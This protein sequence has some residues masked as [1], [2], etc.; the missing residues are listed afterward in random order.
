MKHL[1]L[2][3]QPALTFVEVG[4]FLF[5]EIFTFK[6]TSLGPK[7]FCFFML[8]PLYFAPELVAQMADEHGV[9]MI[10]QPEF[11]HWIGTSFR[12]GVT[13][14]LILSGYQ[15]IERL[16]T[17]QPVMR[18]TIS[19]ETV[20]KEVSRPP[21]TENDSQLDDETQKHHQISALE[22]Q[23][24]IFAL[25]AMTDAAYLYNHSTPVWKA[26]QE[27]RDAACQLSEHNITLPHFEAL[28]RYLGGIVDA[29]KWSIDNTGHE[30]RFTHG[31][32]TADSLAEARGQ[33]P[34]MKAD[35]PH[36]ALA[37]ETC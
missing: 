5:V 3:T 4:F 29:A 28:D 24:T 15:V 17:H 6:S 2:Y 34:I 18:N 26:Q 8:L 14:I 27:L 12:V 25:R 21:K 13:V 23:R 35:A 16:R 19:K 36:A 11:T 1:K 9:Y 7:L 33:R 10:A 37:K 32:E 22:Y 31:F 30:F 20:S